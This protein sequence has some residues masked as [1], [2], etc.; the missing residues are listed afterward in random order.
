M[1]L[2]TAGGQILIFSTDVK[3][4]LLVD[5]SPLNFK[6]TT[7]LDVTLNAPRTST[8]GL[9]TWGDISAV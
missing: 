8:L 3:P 2:L 5:L 4:S 9:P 1:L 6:T 7:A